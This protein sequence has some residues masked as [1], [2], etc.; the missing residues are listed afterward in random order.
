MNYRLARRGRDREPPRFYDNNY[1]YPP[2][3]PQR[4]PPP[5]P[6][7]CH[8]RFMHDPPPPIIF[9]HKTNQI[10]T[11]RYIPKTPQFN[12]ETPTYSTTVDTKVMTNFIL[13]DE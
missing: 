10:P 8:G 4:L 13:C 11:P 2:I 5:E 3:P 1:Y 9:E 6:N 7:I 12:Y